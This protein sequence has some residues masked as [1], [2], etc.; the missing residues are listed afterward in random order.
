LAKN[1]DRKSKEQYDE[2]KRY[3]ISLGIPEYQ[4]D[5]APDDKIW[6]R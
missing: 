6:E 3:G 1:I 4:V 5:F 2:A